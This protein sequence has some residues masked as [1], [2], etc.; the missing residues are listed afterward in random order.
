MSIIDSLKRLERAGE[1][2]SRMTQK[3]KNAAQEVAKKIIE[4]VPAGIE[5][6]RGYKVTKCIYPDAH[7]YIDPNDGWDWCLKTKKSSGYT[8]DD[9]WYVFGVNQKGHT[10][11][12]NYE[13]LE[14]AN[15]ETCLQFAKDISEG[16]L[17]EIAEVLEKR[18]EESKKAIEEF[19]K[20][21]VNTAMAE[22]LPSVLFK[23]DSR[24]EG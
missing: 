20:D 17:D 6:P 23:S 15:R 3:L 22:R 24:Y 14:P 5:L 13:G 7:N 19:E 10:S 4:E 2:N 8:M 18:A 11:S 16:L 12:P 1:E 21:R 9:R